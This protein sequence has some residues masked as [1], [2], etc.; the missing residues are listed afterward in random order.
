MWCLGPVT[1]RINRVGVIFICFPILVCF[2]H[3]AFEELA[4][5]FSSPS[6]LDWNRTHESAGWLTLCL[7]SFSEM[8]FSR[9]ILSKLKFFCCFVSAK[10]LFPPVPLVH[11]NLIQHLC[12][13][14]SHSRV[15]IV[16]NRFSFVVCETFP[17]P[18]AAGWPIG[19]VECGS[20]SSSSAGDVPWRPSSLTSV[21]QQPSDI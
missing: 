10:A 7:S 15:P 8:C 18:P 9:M 13:A 19:V 20:L 4:H 11:A 16:L 17:S 1:P 14:S 5:N 2:S 6:G 12:L 21:L 3:P